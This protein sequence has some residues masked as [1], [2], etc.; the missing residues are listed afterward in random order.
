MNIPAQKSGREVTRGHLLAVFN[1]LLLAGDTPRPAVA[2]IIAEAGVSRSTFYD[3]FDGVEA[4]LNESLRSLLGD[5]A[6]CL[7]GRQPVL[8]LEWLLAHI[9][10]NR[11]TARDFLTGSRGERAKAALAR[12]ISER[13]EWDGDTRLA[14]ILVG[15]TAISAL[16]AWVT[17]RVSADPETMAASL[18]RSTQAILA[19]RP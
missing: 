2:R 7:T 15:G 13:L 18:Q 6:D 8:R 14:G 17:G 9:A 12:A 16:A 5:L 10:E 19:A 1:R 3:H 11:G 4:L